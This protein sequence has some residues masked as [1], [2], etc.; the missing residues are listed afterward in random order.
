MVSDEGREWT[1]DPKHQNSRTQQEDDLVHITLM[2]KTRT[3]FNFFVTLNEQT[4]RKLSEP[5]TGVSPIPR[6]FCK[7]TP[8]LV[9]TDGLA[10][11]EFT[12]QG[13]GAEELMAYLEL[14]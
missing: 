9:A 6:G 10:L 14:N 5:S 11:L 12:K 3:R 4:G 13:L 2:Q 1:D 8:Y 7:V